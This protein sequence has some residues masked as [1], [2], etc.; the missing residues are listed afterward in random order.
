ME[1]TKISEVDR[2]NLEL[3]KAQKKIV[4]M[5][6]EKAIVQNELADMIYRYNVLKLYMKYK[7]SEDDA[8]DESGTIILGG[9]L[10]PVSNEDGK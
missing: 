2:L 9:A 3:S 5:Q 10:S 7:L 6:A 1:S 4:T 8:I